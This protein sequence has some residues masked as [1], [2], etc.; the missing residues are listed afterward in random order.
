MFKKILAVFLA[1]LMLVPACLTYSSAEETEQVKTECGGSCGVTPTIIVHGLGQSTVAMTD[2]S[3][4]YVYDENGELE[5][6]WPL[7]VEAAPLV[8][9]LLRPLLKTLITQKDYIGVPLGEAALDVFKYNICDDEGRQNENVA[10]VKYLKSV[11]E[12]TP[13]EKE[14]LYDT[15]PL[16]KYCGLAGTTEDHLYYFMYNSFGNNRDIAEEFIEFVRMVKAETGHD[17]VNIVPISLGGTVMNAAMEYYREELVGCVDKIVYIVPATNGS[18]LISDLYM[19]RF[20]TDDE[21][22]YLTM[23]PTLIDGWTGYLVNVALRLLKNETVLSIIDNVLDALVGGFLDKCTNMWALSCYEDWEEIIACHPGF[24]AEYPEIYEQ[25]C[26]YHEAQGNRD[27]N[28]RYLMDNGAKVFDIVDTDYPLYCIVPSWKEYNAD[29]IIQIDST[30]LGCVSCPKGDTLEYSDYEGKTQRCTD[31]SHNHINHANTVD[32]SYGFAPETT[33]YLYGQDHEGTARDD[34][35]LNLAMDIL[36]GNVEDVHSDP[37][38]PQFMFGRE[39]RNMIN[40]LA[41]YERMKEE[42]RLSPEQ[43]AAVAPA[44]A[45]CEK[46]LADNLA[47]DTEF[48]KTE[49][50]LDDAFVAAGLAGADEESRLEIWAGDFFR[51]MSDRLYAK[52]GNRGFCELLRR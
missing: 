33:W 35:I 27:A 34:I 47:T 17:K 30:S 52:Y 48:A 45:E 4:G 1:A 29:G 51:K 31:R 22:L 40:R 41:S 21:S 13:K 20:C 37:R 7:S 9:K 11:A 25:I 50:A 36:A 18:K 42:G 12:C 46:V 24:A 6:V 5:E 2:G 14:I 32:A 28:L 23:F 38:Y 10:V 16:E 49:K 19:H 8:K 15:V 44:A 43:I 3:G 39:S 26:A